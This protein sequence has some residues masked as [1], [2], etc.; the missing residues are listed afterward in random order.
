MGAAKGKPSRTLSL[1][2]EPGE[3]QFCE[4]G[5]RAAAVGAL[6][7]TVQAA[8]T[9]H[10]INRPTFGET[11]LGELVNTLSE[12][13]LAVTERGSMARPEVM[14]MTQATTLDAV[15]NTLARRAT[16]NMG[17]HLGAADTYWRL[18]FR[19]QA[20]CRATL[21]ALAEIK[22]PR[23]V[24]IAKQANIAQQQQVNN[25]PAPAAPHA[26]TTETLQN[27]LFGGAPHGIELDTRA[28]GAAGGADRHLE[29][30][31]AV[32]GAAHA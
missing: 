2:P 28:Q 32:H 21:E 13:A 15:F 1:K 18:A 16:A 11:D 25:H 9:I 27:G 7:P 12:H 8:A 26:G 14:L 31:G 30:V 20:Q 23:P 3:P 6:R 22:N 19:A 24:L 29:A 4:N 5:P 10:E 17:E